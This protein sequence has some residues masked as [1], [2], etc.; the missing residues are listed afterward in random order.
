[1]LDIL[2]I[3]TN[4]KI[5]GFYPNNILDIGCH[6]GTWTQEVLK[7]F[8]KSNYILFDAITYIE[9]QE[10][11]N[12][13]NNIQYYNELLGEKEDEVIWY[14][15]KNSGDSIFK[16][17]TNIYSECLEIKKTTK[18]LDNIIPEN[19][20]DLI[21]LDVQGSEIPILKGATKTIKHTSFIILEIQ[22]MGK[23]NNSVPIFLEHIKYMDT[24]NYIL[25][26]IVE[27]HKVNN[28][29]I[30]VDIIFINKNKINGLKINT[31]LIHSQMLSAF[32]REHVIN[33]VER[34]KIENINYKVIDIGGSAEYTNWSHNIIDYIADLMNPPETINKI[35][36][37]KLNFNYES[38]WQ[39][40]L[41]FVEENGKFDFS[42][43]SHV[44]EDISTPAVLIKMLGKISKEGFIAFPSKYRELK[45]INDNKYV[46]YSHH[47][48]I[49]SFNNNK[50]IAYPKL[51]F[52]QSLPIMNIGENS[53]LIDFSFFWKNKLNL[54][55]V[56]NDY[57]GPTEKQVFDYYNDLI[58]DDLDLLKKFVNN[59]SITNKLD[60]IYHSLLHIE[61]LKK[62]NINSSNR[63]IIIIPINLNYINSFLQDITYMDSQDYIPY[64]I[65]KINKIDYIL[66]EIYIL[67]IKKNDI[68]N[69]YVDNIITNLL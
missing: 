30:Q 34:K 20:Y 55:I 29:I 59:Y 40:I 38:E 10:L 18:L 22:F 53:D 43:C 36:Y 39:E 4:L 50:F 48:W 31:P 46:G 13:Y 17:R 2:N 5:K 33:Y 42:I 24:I 8:H 61:Y 47:R 15:K 1:M 11:L 49:Y 3:L 23:Y 19:I 54:N 41:D 25:Y 60:N 62:F 64:D 21:K 32:D 65:A 7:V 37:F 6:K 28:I 35:K 67:F 63:L 9:I 26:D 52:I 16:E 66:S 14:Q 51:N 12:T 68:L 69:T 44:I 56:N 45:E 57:L 27:I 58:N